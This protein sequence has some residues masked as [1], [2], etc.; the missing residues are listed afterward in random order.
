LLLSAQQPPNFKHKAN[1]TI[2]HPSAKK[3]ASTHSEDA[4]LTVK[5]YWKVTVSGR[6]GQIS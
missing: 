6:S 3:S 4:L 2:Y 5:S 1:D